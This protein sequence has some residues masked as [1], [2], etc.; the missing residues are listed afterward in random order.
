M[1]LEDGSVAW[2]TTSEE[3]CRAA[4]DNVEKMLEQ[5]GTQP[6]KVFG[7]KAG[8]RP[9]PAPYRPE[10]DVTKVLGDDLHSRYLQLIGVLRW[11]IELGRIDI[12]T[13]VSVLS[14]HQCNPREGH[15]NALYKIFRNHV[16]RWFHIIGLNVGFLEEGTS[17]TCIGTRVESQ[18]GKNI[19]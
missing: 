6:L 3:Y 13:E 18:Y 4:I 16:E 15:L 5:E 9:F 1:Q 14:Q 10:V 11:A 12:I 2:S 17:G 7:T 19:D 8:E